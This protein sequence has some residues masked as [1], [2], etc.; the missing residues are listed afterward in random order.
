MKAQHKLSRQNRGMKHFYRHL[1]QNNKHHTRMSR[2]SRLIYGGVRIT[3]NCANNSQI[4]EYMTQN[5]GGITPIYEHNR[6]NN[7]GAA[8]NNRY[9]RQDNIGYT[10][11]NEE[12]TQKSRGKKQNNVSET[13][14]FVNI[15]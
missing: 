10:L 2:D 7:K 11:N 4:N 9:I 15:T 14:R 6:A 8:L 5:A 13:Q 3:P 12:V 1:K